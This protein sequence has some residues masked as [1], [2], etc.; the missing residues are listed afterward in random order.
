MFWLPEL[1][2]ARAA[3]PDCARICCL[4]K[5]DISSAMLASRIV[6]SADCVFETCVCRTATADCNRFIPAPIVPRIAA[7]RVQCVLDVCQRTGRHVI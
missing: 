5:F 4:V 3:I 1:A 6:D 2:W 7:T